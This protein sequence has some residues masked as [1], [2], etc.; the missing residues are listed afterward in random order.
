MSV[1]D[2]GRRRVVV[3][4]ADVREGVRIANAARGE[5]CLL[6]LRPRSALTG[7]SPAVRVIEPA[8]RRPGHWYFCAEQADA[9]R[10]FDTLV[11]CGYDRCPLTVTFAGCAWAALT[12][13][14][15]RRLLGMFRDA[16]I[17]TAGPEPAVAEPPGTVS[18]VFK[19][20]ATCHVRRYASS[21]LEAPPGRAGRVSV[22]I[23]LF[24]QGRYV[25]EAVASVRRDL[26]EAEIVVVND[27]STDSETNRVFAG[28]RGVVKVDQPNQGLSGAR[29]AGIE[30]STGTYVVPLD[31]D[32]TIEPGFLPAARR[33]LDAEPGLAHVV[34]Y[35]EYTGL[36]KLTYVP[37]GF[38]PELNLFLHTHGK[39]TGMFRRDALRSIGGYDRR[40]R[41][42]EDWEIQVAL[43]RAGHRT[44]VMPLV[45]HSYRRH[46]DSMSFS[47][48]NKIRPHL[49]Q[50]LMR[51]HLA[52]LDPEDL[53]TG[54]LVLANLW[55][56]EYEPSTS[57]LL[58][59]GRPTP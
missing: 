9:D 7:L 59:R 58:Q 47:V 48:S 39:A 31:A 21:V 41:A 20:W 5:I 25:R 46:S 2:D 22:V 34:G 45:G 14:R 12:L 26:P 35:V 28:L 49:V 51:K 10:V 13:V 38:I 19:R 37:A 29:N 3:C 55:K 40:F 15:A 42:F 24:N 53:R 44:E 56:T 27:G 52:M 57:V 23:P 43:H 30:R 18:D 8:G 36:L 32:D 6:E 4:G 33:A 16:T 11:A 17:E 1:H 54:M 50:Q